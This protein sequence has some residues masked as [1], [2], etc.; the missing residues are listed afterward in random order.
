VI[1]C[2]STNAEHIELE[3]THLNTMVSN[4]LASAPVESE[5]EVACRRVGFE[6][7]GMTR[8]TLQHGRKRASM[9]A[10]LSAEETAGKAKKL[11]LY[12]KAIKAALH[13]VRESEKPVFGTMLRVYS[14]LPLSN[15]HVAPGQRS[16]QASTR[17]RSPK[18][19]EVN[20]RL[21]MMN[22][23]DYELWTYRRDWLAERWE[24]EDQ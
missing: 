23:D 2:A 11:A 3:S 10:A 17:D 15:D 18:A 6:L 19:W 20:S 1:A 8:V 13:H 16:P 24:S 12:Q 7:F 9:R 14:R 4:G 22:P 5:H 21:L